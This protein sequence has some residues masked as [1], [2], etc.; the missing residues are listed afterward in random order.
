MQLIIITGPSG[1]GKSTVAKSIKEMRLDNVTFPVSITT[2]QRRE[3]EKDGIDYRYVSEEVFDEMLQNDK[4]LE[5]TEFDRHRYGTD[6]DSFEALL[7][8]K[9]LVVLEIDLI[10]A[11][12][13]ASNY[14]N[15]TRVCLLPPDRDTLY[16]RL[17]NRRENTEESIA[18]RISTYNESSSSIH[19]CEIKLINRDLEETVVTISKMI[20]KKVEHI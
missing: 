11:D 19:D 20:K 12:F 5:W 7:S 14:S 3:N 2:R 10:G 16:K 17:R 13:F 6:R 8:S 18:R 15:V 4:I 1:V 9:P